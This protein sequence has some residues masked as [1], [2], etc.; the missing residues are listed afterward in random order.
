VVVA[1]ERR[2]FDVV[3]SEHIYQELRRALDNP[4][5]R[6]RLSPDQATDLLT[7]VR[8]RATFVAISASVEGVASH[9]EDDIVLST[10]LSASAD[11]LVTGDR[12]LLRLATYSGVRIVNARELVDILRH[13]P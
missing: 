2:D 1:W 13:A 11:Y 9:P 3:I 6:R 7:L 8:T 5:F 4:Y 10:A 12:Q